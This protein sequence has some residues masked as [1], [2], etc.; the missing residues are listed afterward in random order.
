MGWISTE[1]LDRRQVKE[2]KD[3]QRIAPALYSFM[4]NFGGISVPMDGVNQ[5]PGRSN[6]TFP[7]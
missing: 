2:M 6:L 4:K 5:S 1:R 7:I 3:D